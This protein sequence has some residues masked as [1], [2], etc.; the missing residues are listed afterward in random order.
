MELTPASPATPPAYGCGMRL[1]DLLEMIC[2]SDPTHWNSID[3]PYAKYVTH[4]EVV[5]ESIQAESFGHYALWVYVD[6]IQISVALSEELDRHGAEY[7]AEWNTF[8]DKR[9]NEHFLDVIYNGQIVYR[10]VVLGVDG[11]RALLPSPKLET[12]DTGQMWHE[13]FTN[14]VTE[15]QFELAQFLARVQ[16]NREFDGYFKQAGFVVL[17]EI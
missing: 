15:L 14:T 1:A 13:P 16:G 5:R 2:Q 12:I 6:D 10:E 7:Q 3:P 9:I 11:G 17:P 8:P 4:L